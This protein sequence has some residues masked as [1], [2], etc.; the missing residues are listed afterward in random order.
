MGESF[1]GYVSVVEDHSLAW[2]KNLPWLSQS[3]LLRSYVVMMCWLEPLLAL[4]LLTLFISSHLTWPL[5]YP[6]STYHPLLFS[7]IL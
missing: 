7:C 3:F 2:S 5:L 6:L 4:D 1:K